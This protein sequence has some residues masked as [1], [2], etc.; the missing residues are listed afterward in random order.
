MHSVEQSWGAAILLYCFGAAFDFLAPHFRYLRLRNA[1]SKF[2][3]PG[4]GWIPDLPDPRDYTGRHTSVRPILTKSTPHELPDAVDLRVGDDG[5]AFFTDAQHQG[6]VN[7][8]TAFT[9]LS[10]VEYL[11][12]CDG[13]TFNGSQLFVYKVARNLRGKSIDNC[14]D[15]GAELRAT[16]KAVQHFGVP[17][18]DIWPYDPAFVDKEPPAFVYQAAKPLASLRFFRPY[19]EAPQTPLAAWD[20]VTSLLAAGCPV[21]LGFPVPSSLSNDSAIPYRPEHDSYLGGMTALAVGYNRHHF[22]R[23]LGALL[24]RTSWGK[25]WGDHGYGWLPKPYLDAGLARD[26]WSACDPSMD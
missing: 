16:L 21:A 13:R 26:F 12:R 14:S 1:V 4:M 17:S 6:A 25:Q 20:A 23:N 11:S 10:M 5:E 7:S 24:I 2:I 18:E 3:P 22:G 15:T 9:V 8:S 19:L